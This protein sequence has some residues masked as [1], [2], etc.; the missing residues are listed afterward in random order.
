MAN[1]NLRVPGEVIFKSQGGYSLV[2][3]GVGVDMKARTMESDTP[4]DGTM[5]LGT[6]SGNRMQADLN[7]RTVLLNG[8]AR[9]HI[10]QGAARAK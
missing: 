8:R 6:F 7:N 10:V 3:R 9:L 4:V 5:P 2:T 1:E